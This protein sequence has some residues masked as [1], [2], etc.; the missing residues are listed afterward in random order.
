MLPE[1]RHHF[2]HFG[3]HQHFF[4]SLSQG[5]LQGL[6]QNQ[7]PNFLQ[8]V[9]DVVAAVVVV[10]AVVLVVVAVVA[11][12][13]ALIV[14]VVAVVV[15]F[16]AVAVAVVVV[17]GSEIILRGFH[18]VSRGRLNL[19]SSCQCCWQYSMSQASKQV[20]EGRLHHLLVADQVFVVRACY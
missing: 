5:S 14:V 9:A 17:T 20:Q 12:K 8:A 4:P 1:L 16:A 19:A 10:I 13:A 11:V 7:P 6:R 18:L 2:L 15:L 3:F